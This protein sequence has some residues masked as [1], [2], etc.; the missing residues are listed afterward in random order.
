MTCKWKMLLVL[1]LVCCLSCLAGGAEQQETAGNFKNPVAVKEVLGGKRTV[2]NAAWWGFNKDDST[3][4]LQ[5]AI[6]SGASKVIV[7]Y[8]GSEWIVRPIKLASNQEVVFEP[9]VVV[10]AKKGEFKGK[11]DCLFTAL[12]KDNITLQGYGAV[13][14]MRKSDYMGSG[15][16]KAQWRH[17]ISLR[18]CSNVKVSG[19]T[20][21]DSGGDGIYL[22]VKRGSV[23]PCKDVLI[24]NCI[25]DNNYRQG[26][27]LISGEN[28]RISNC[29][30]R[31]THG[32]PPGA[33]IDLEPNSAKDRL[34]NVV[35]SKCVLENNAGPGL[36]VS[37]R[38]LSSESNDVSILFVGCYVKGCSTGL[39]IG[40]IKDNVPKGL[41]EFRDCTVQGTDSAGLFIGN[42][43]ANILHLR[44]RNCKWGDVAKKGM[45]PRV[46]TAVPIFFILKEPN[47]PQTFGGVEFVN[48]YVY[49]RN[50][51]P[52]LAVTDD[53]RR[54]PVRDVKGQI[55]VHNPHGVTMNW[56]S[57]KKPAALKVSTISH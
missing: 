19:L 28:I 5:G 44:F 35:I 2:A 52:F 17:V 43:S 10:A 34:V 9:G 27:S 25:F 20:L 24:D 26:I 32:S 33:G 40:A 50:R 48:C 15:Y 30:L 47:Y 8:M 29:T 16:V 12:G 37:L 55:Y 23:L 45:Y 7:P 22:G 6:N 31:N 3:D 13:L 49:D 57:W 42:K 1:I 4:A 53:I 39:Q 11:G 46:P 38:H 14:R 54:S 21:R 56:G 18:S 41:I 51:R 36:A